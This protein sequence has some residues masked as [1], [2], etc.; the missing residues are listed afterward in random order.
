ML[1]NLIKYRFIVQRAGGKSIDIYSI[2]LLNRRPFGKKS[3]MRQS[4]AAIC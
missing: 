1:T 3:K 4:N 2:Y